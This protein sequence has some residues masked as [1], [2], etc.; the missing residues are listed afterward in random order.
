MDVDQ[1]ESDIRR[2]KESLNCI[3]RQLEAETK[4]NK[5]IDIN[6]LIEAL[7]GIETD[8]ATLASHQNISL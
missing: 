6:D 3:V 8:I 7:I 5:T 1:L 2:L 4:E